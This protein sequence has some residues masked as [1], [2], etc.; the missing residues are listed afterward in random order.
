MQ[1]RHACFAHIASWVCPTSLRWTVAL[2]A[3]EEGAGVRPFYAGRPQQR[4]PVEVA[5]RDSDSSCG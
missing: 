2:A 1:V 3:A 5:G 4:A